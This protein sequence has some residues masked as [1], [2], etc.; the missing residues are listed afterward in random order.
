MTTAPRVVRLVEREARI[1]R[2]LWHGI[3]FSAFVSPLLF[4]LAMGVGVGGYVDRQ[5]DATLRG[6]SY[7]Q[8]VAP[9]LL[10]ANVVQLAVGDSLWWVMGGTKWDRRYH[11]MVASPLASEA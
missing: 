5:A 3:V 7:L 4:L 8:F 6:L 11:G 2:R 10:A 1:M 9:G